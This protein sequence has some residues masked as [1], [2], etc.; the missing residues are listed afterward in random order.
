MCF[1]WSSVLLTYLTSTN[2]VSMLM[3]VDWPHIFLIG[4]INYYLSGL[5]EICWLF[6]GAWVGGVLCRLF[7]RVCLVV[8]VGLFFCCL[9]GWLLSAW[10]GGVWFGWCCLL[11]GG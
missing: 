11:A 2:S 6:V 9:V 5:D 3:R 7:G 8:S 10:V 4:I 1:G